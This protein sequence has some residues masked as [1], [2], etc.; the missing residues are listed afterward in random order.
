MRDIF[1]KIENVSSSDYNVYAIRQIT[2]A[3]L[4]ETLANYLKLPANVAK[5][6]VITDNQTSHQILHQQ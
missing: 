1:R 6:K 3:Y 5:Q 4:P 2:Q